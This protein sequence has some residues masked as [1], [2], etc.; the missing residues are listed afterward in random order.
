LHGVPQ[1]ANQERITL[2]VPLGSLLIGP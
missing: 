2:R 1:G